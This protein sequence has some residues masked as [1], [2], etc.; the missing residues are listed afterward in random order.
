MESFKEKVGFKFKNSA[1]FKERVVIL[2]LII[3]WITFFLTNENFRRVDNYLSILREASF[4]GVAAIGMTFCLTIGAIDLSIGSMLS[5]LSLVTI[6]MLGNFG[7]ILTII[8][9]LFLGC[10]CGV[11]N[12]I[13]YARLR[14]PTFI[15]TLA[16]AYIFKAFA[17]IYS[18]GNPVIQ[19]KEK[20]FTVIGNGSF[21]SIPI[22]FIIFILLAVFGEV[23]L[24]RTPMGRNIM[25]IGYSEKA[26]YLSGVNIKNI[27][28]FVFGLVGMFTAAAAILIS[29]RLWSA[30]VDM[31]SGYEFDVIAAVVLGGT[32]LSGGNGSIFNTVIGAIFFSSIFTGM[33]MFHVNSYMQKVVEGVILLVAFSMP[34]ARKIVKNIL[35]GNKVIENVGK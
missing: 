33:N 29:S 17:L 30:N 10:A 19:F 27:K 22:P 2:S 35:F 18:N 15:S 20:W 24:K 13:L 11:I 9:V 14:V 23:I 8:A 16:M 5:L 1:Y 28:V 6:S 4:I 34:G 26:S 3:L 7:L 32:S 31:K 21:G 12:G 25:A